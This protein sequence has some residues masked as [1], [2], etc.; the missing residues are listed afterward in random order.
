MFRKSSKVSNVNNETVNSLT[1][2]RFDQKWQIIQHFTEWIKHGDSKIQMLLTIEGVII[3]GYGAMSSVL[4]S[5]FKSDNQIF[6][7]IY[8]G[9]NVIFTLLVLW[10]IWYGFFKAL[11]PDTSKGKN[12]G[13]SD[14]LFFYGTY[15]NEDLSND[16]D[17]A[18]SQNI[19]E[20]VNSQIA[21]LGRIASG[22]YERIVCLQ[23]SVFFSS[24]LFFVI[25]I[26]GFLKG[27]M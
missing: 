21:A 5:G 20:F 1:G 2:L 27:V 3:A 8:I 4:L 10:T 9:M 24:A 25:A 7:W 18:S 12:D 15:K 26:V 13:E 6:T 17:E 16:L 14:N 19:S 23:R 11:H 22:K